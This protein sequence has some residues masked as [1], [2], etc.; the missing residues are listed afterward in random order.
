MQACGIEVKD[1]TERDFIS[2]C[3]YHGNRDTPAFSTSKT[4]GYS[5]CFN[6]ACAIGSD[7]RLTLERLVREIKGVNHFEAKRLILK[8][9]NNVDLQD[10]VEQMLSREPEVLP[11][12]PQD[13]IDL[14]HK[15]FVEE[16]SAAREYMKGR[17]FDL[18]TMM[19]FK[20]GFT[21]ATYKP[22]SKPDMIVVPAFDF[23]GRPVGLVGR[24]IVGKEFKNFGPGPN[25]SGFHKSKIIW[26]L[27]NAR[28]YRTIILT[29]ATFDSMRV[30]QAGYP[31]VGAL[32]GGSLSSEQ[33]M[34]LRRHFDKVIIMTDFDS[35]IYHKMCRKCLR[36]G[37]EYCQGHQPGR[38]LGM[39]IAERLPDLD[40]MWATHDDVNVYPNDAKDAGDMTDEEIRRCLRNAIPHHEYVD[41]MVA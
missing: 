22:V 39:K 36:A 16:A 14:M 3:P 38:D 2:L 18:E 25:G 9:K 11:E 41:W 24:S 19:H 21:P 31:N 12:F 28:K 1:E 10:E 13:A 32:L 7:D 34:L 40:V 17:G 15:R 20:V 33:E 37:N 23:K 4:M 5:I 30:H 29:E 8:N 35:P 27:H 6:P 26:N